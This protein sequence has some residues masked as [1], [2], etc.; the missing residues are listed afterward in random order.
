MIKINI[1]NPDFLN[2]WKN[3]QSKE[4][5]ALINTLD[6]LHNIIKY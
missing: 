2:E 3:L 6:L 1:N 4:H 5:E